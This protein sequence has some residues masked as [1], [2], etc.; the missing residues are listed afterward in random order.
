MTGRGYEFLD[1]ELQKITADA[2]IGRRAVDKLVKVWLKSGSELWVLI[3][4]EI[5]G[6]RESGFALRI[7]VYHYRIFDRYRAPVA[8][9]VILADDDENWRPSEYREELLGTK[10]GF[11]FPAIKLI[12]YRARLDELQRSDNVFAIVTLAQ[13]AA[14]ETRK[15]SG[16]RLS[17]KFAL[18]RR[19]YERGFDKRRVIG[20]FRFLDWVL[21]LPAEL[22]LEFRD[23]L[24]KYEE[25][26]KMPYVTSIELIG[27]AKGIAKG[28]AEGKAEGGAEILLRQ[29][30]RR[31][32]SLEEQ[33]Q[34]RIR[35]LSLESLQALSDIVF[36][37]KSRAD[38]DEWLRLQPIA[39]PELPEGVAAPDATESFMS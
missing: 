34:I 31:F 2:E 30:Q 9:F 12:D 37:L 11:E 1:K 10:V 39:P 18:T 21:V 19:L 15:D 29:L 16:D 13:L 20:L 33:S 32:G 26:R 36:D 6:Q 27:I 5:Q 35:Q 22:A 28:K 17:R 4:I 8:T 23:K 25:E 7:Y 24:S 38:L 14:M 3:H